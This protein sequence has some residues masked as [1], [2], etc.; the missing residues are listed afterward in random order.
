VGLSLA[1]FMAFT[2]VLAPVALILLIVLGLGVLV[3]LAGMAA[4]IDDRISRSRRWR[5]GL[6]T[7]TCAAT[8][9]LAPYVPVVGLLAIIVVAAVAL[10]AVGLSLQRGTSGLEPTAAPARRGAGLPAGPGPRPR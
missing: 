10:G 2:I 4:A 1:V 8:L 7:V 9:V 6:G 5:S 3:G